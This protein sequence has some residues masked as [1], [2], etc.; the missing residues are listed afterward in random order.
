M[1]EA[2]KS[3]SLS[4]N[5]KLFLEFFGA[6]QASRAYFAR[7]YAHKR[8]QLYARSDFCLV[9]P[10]DGN[11]AG[12]V[13]DVMS[14]GSSAQKRQPGNMLWGK[15]M[16]GLTLGQPRLRGLGHSRLGLRK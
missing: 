15:V 2:S 6:N 16:Q 11:T 3:E 8:A 13:F 5:P 10:G 14:F 9:M 4:G 12:R 1:E 7:D